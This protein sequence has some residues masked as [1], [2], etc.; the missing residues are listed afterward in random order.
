[1]ADK[2]LDKGSSGEDI[3]YDHKWG[4]TDTY[5][6]V[7]PDHTVTVTGSRYALSG[8]VMHE[9]LPFV[10]EMLDIRQ[11]LEMLALKLAFPHLT[12][13][14]IAKARKILTTYD[15]SDDPQEWRDLN[16]A[17]HMALYA[18]CKRP[19]LIKMIEDVVLV[20]YRFLRTYISQ[21]VGRVDPQAEHY[22]IL[23]AC[24]DGDCPK[25]LALLETHIEHTRAALQKRR[26]SG[27]PTAPSKSNLHA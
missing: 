23:D 2:S 19:R 3:R 9:F 8:T 11:A 21:T 14:D 7:N 27:P 6:K 15:N 20:N 17:F 13:Q 10:E 1:M 24:A 4:F 18:P 12:P 26:A 25:A 22:A 5:F 16:V